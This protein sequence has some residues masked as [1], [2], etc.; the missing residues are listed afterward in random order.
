[1]VLLVSASPQRARDLYC[2]E[3]CVPAVL[4]E[5]NWTFL[6]SIFLEGGCEDA[7]KAL[8]QP[9]VSCDL[10]RHDGS[11]MVRNKLYVLQ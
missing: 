6:P 11:I 9:V 5:G 2:E 3:S 8:K 7:R 4:P 1:M 10:L